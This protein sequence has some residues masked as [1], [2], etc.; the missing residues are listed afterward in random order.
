M[1]DYAQIALSTAATSKAIKRKVGAVVTGPTELYAAA[2]NYNSDPENT[3]CEDTD[4][5]TLSSVIHAEV[6]ALNSFDIANFGVAPIEIYITHQPCKKCLEAI[7]SAGIKPE[8]I[9]IAEQFM[10]FDTDKLRIDLLP[11]A[12]QRFVSPNTFLS[13]YLNVIHEQDYAELFKLG[14]LLLKHTTIVDVA[15]VFTF[16]AKKYKPNNWRTVE[17]LDRYWAALGRH[18]IQMDK[19]PKLKDTESKLK[20]AAHALTNVIFLLEL[21]DKRS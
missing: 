19:N 12:A 18:L 14:K 11:K 15:E 6:A 21:T 3:I 1:I 4:G 10:K 2:C 5:K 8:N 20:H 17:S 9:H 7:M 13:K 16:G